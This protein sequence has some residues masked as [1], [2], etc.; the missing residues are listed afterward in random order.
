MSLLNPDSMGAY[1]LEESIEAE[2]DGLPGDECGYD[3]LYGITCRKCKEDGL[4]WKNDGITKSG[5]SLYKL[6]VRHACS[7]NKGQ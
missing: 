4:Y 1:F 2:F 7:N 5:W 6:K 3:G